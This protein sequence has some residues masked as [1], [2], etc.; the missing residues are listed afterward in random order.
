[1]VIKPRTDL[2]KLKD[3]DPIELVKKNEVIKIKG[4]ASASRE[5]RDAE[6]CRRMARGA[7]NKLSRFGIP[8]KISE[9]YQE[10]ASTGAVISLWAVPGH[11][12]VSIG[13]DALG[14]P[15]RRSEAVGAEAGWKM[16]QVLDSPAAVDP[17]LSDNLM[18][19]L[20]LLGGRIKTNE[21]TGHI[22]SNIYVC[23]KFLDVKFRI[24]EKEKFISVD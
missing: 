24:D 15:K 21:I 8:I 7:R 14:E 22:K 18:P 10:T 2:G 6:V 4:I 20:A 5:L 9:D 19:I 13:A 16:Q 3:I 11:G 17:Y 12:L 23:E 1:M